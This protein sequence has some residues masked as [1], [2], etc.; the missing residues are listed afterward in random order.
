MYIYRKLREAYDTYNGDINKLIEIYKNLTN[1][2]IDRNKLLKYLPSTLNGNLVNI[3]FERFCVLLVDLSTD[4]E[5]EN[6]DNNGCET[7]NNDGTIYFH[8]LL[9]NCTF[10]KAWHLLK[11]YI[12]QP[13]INIL[14]SNLLLNVVFSCLL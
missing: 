6:N 10:L 2:S 9:W 5:D 3:T 4:I 11:I 12:Y 7:T 1:H 14:G 13:L 8:L